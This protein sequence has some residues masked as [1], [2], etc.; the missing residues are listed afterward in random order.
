MGTS[1]NTNEHTE[2]GRVDRYEAGTQYT[3]P[4]RRGRKGGQHA[5]ES[6]DPE[7][8]PRGPGAGSGQEPEAAPA[9]TFTIEQFNQ[10]RDLFRGAP[11]A[12]VDDDQ[13]D[14][15]D[16][17]DGQ[18]AAA[19]PNPLGT[20]AARASV[21][22]EE[23]VYRKGD[24]SRSF[25]RDAFRARMEGD[26]DAAERF[27]KWQRQLSEVA[28]KY[29]ETTVTQP[30]II[31]P[32]YRADLLVEPDVPARP[33]LSRLTGMRVNLTDATPFSVPIRGAADVVGDHVEGTAHVA[34]GTLTTSEITVTP[35]A[36]SGAFEVSR[37]LVDSSNPAID[38]VA[39]ASILED[40]DDKAETYAWERIV[41]A[42]LDKDGGT[43]LAALTPVTTINTP[44]LLE[45]ELVAFFTAR[46]RP[47]SFAASGSEMFT[48][49]IGYRDGDNRPMYP[50]IAPQNAAGTASVSDAEYG[51]NVRAVPFVLSSAGSTDG[52]DQALLIR[53]ADILAGESAVRRFRFEEVSGPGVIKLALW[54]YQAITRMRSTGARLIDLDATNP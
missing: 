43:V 16:V 51:V 1:L 23:E 27:G 21:T 46:L 18:H 40:Y 28:E 14:D 47:A 48:E 2:A 45:A 20:P 22:Y 54:G 12:D 4:P 39:W 6:D 3:P 49:V 8:P 35:K 29:V 41:G 44:E 25:V 17:N 11:A 26:H 42:S 10:M 53:Q 19:S 38:R 33:I 34:A 5:G 36:V 13:D 52:A 7:R 15:Q 31:P 30:S 24:T 9:P 50:V 32:G 37:E